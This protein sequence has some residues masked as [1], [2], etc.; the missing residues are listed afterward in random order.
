MFAHC[1]QLKH[2]FLAGLFAFGFLATFQIVGHASQDFPPAV[3][4]FG[5][6]NSEGEG[7]ETEGSDYDDLSLAIP[8]YYG[9][10][11]VWAS[12][13]PAQDKKFSNHTRSLL[14]PPDPIHS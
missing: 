12:A 6:T 13:P 5:G 10:C 3:A 7:A 8:F 2:L 4:D 11:G 1:R 9:P 14:K